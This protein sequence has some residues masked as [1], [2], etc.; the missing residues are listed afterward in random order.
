MLAAAI[1]AALNQPKQPPAL[2]PQ[3]SAPILAR[4]YTALYR[5]LI[6][7]AAPRPIPR[8]PRPSAL[9]SQN[10]SLYERDQ[11]PVSTAA[12]GGLS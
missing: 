9:R 10:G 8:S 2:L 4:Q 12:K 6:A 7:S 3:F 5:S 11:R 1:Q